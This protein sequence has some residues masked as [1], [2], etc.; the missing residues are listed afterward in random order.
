MEFG[1]LGEE[2]YK[3]TYARTLADGTSENWPMTVER[4]VRGNAYLGGI[5]GTGEFSEED[6][7]EA[8]LDMRI[9]PAGRHLW[10]SGSG[11]G[12]GLFNCHRAGWGPELETHFTFLFDQL[13]LGGGVGANYS[14]DYLDSLPGLRGVP[15]VE[16]ILDPAHP[17]T[18][19]FAMA[20][21]LTD[22][23][24]R[25][26]TYTVEDSREGWVEALRLLIQHSVT[27]TS[28]GLVF[29]LSNVRGAGAPI[30]GFGGTA[31]GPLPLAQMLLSV[32]DVLAECIRTATL[33]DCNRTLTPLQAME[34]DHA[35]ASCVVAG[36]V[37]RSARMSIL[38]WK[39]PYIWEFITCKSDSSSH[40]STNISVEVDDEF[41]ER[42]E[43]EEPLAQR[44]LLMIS[45]GMLTNGEPGIFNSSLASSGER[46]DVRST[47]P[48]G[49]I[50][51]EEWEQCCLGHVNLAHP[52]H[53]D[54][55]SKEIL[56][57]F[58]MMGAFLVRATLGH[59]SDQRQEAVK[60]RNRR[61]GVGFFGYQEWL[62]YRGVRYSEAGESPEVALCLAEWKG[63]AKS[64]A[65]A[66]ADRLRV[67]RPIKV[68]TIAPTG[69]IAKLPG[70]TEGIHPVYAKHF[71]RRVRYA[72]DSGSLAVLEAAGYPIEDDLY[73]ART[74]V[75]SFYV[76]DLAVAHYGGMIQDV[77]ELSLTDMLAAQ[78]LVQRMYAD[79]AV[80]YTVNIRA[81]DYSV[82]EMAAAL[83]VYGPYL[84]GTTVF[85]DMSRPQSPMERITKE[86]YQSSLYHE[87][88]Q[89]L[90]D[91][92]LTGSCPVR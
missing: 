55:D 63:E 7:Y 66:E 87:E 1:P 19:A 5:L 43:A 62:A 24:P 74:K 25:V 35:I 86:E 29:D 67:N 3:R 42:V 64:S 32:R 16:I 22:G 90:N 2:V 83:S 81:E 4:V 77:E 40:W 12:L 79:N 20:G 10:A 88:G 73:S 46:G 82:A 11:S 54:S 71:I 9:I 44:I 56:R 8:I 92:C 36:N 50:A 69:T 57:S 85:P 26:P 27:G 6:L 14:S 61:I 13:M 15:M 39:D 34:I 41:W 45:E 53:L 38:H 75:V 76:E 28:S 59:S 51:L 49:E 17:D 80:S 30:A 33:A 58:R 23:I 52:A 60:N 65:Y 91:N 48:C 78:M 18:G 47:N 31:S 89:S 37:R 21:V 68:T 84:K 72:E 70:T